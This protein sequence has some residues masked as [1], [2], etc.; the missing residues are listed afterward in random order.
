MQH[1]RITEHHDCCS[2]KDIY[3][4]STFVFYARGKFYI[5]TYNDCLFSSKPQTDKIAEILKLILEKL[6]PKEIDVIT[7]FR[8]Q[9]NKTEVLQAALLKNYVHEF[10]HFYSNNFHG[11]MALV[12]KIPYADALF[13]DEDEY[14]KEYEK[15]DEYLIKYGFERFRKDLDILYRRNYPE[16]VPEIILVQTINELTNQIFKE[17]T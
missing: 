2:D 6:E 11:L 14:T 17:T 10:H 7:S 13:L 1:L 8:V 5:C 15:A 12:T 4:Q 16:Y 3:C 9:A